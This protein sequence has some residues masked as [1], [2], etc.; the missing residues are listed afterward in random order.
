MPYLILSQPSVEYA[1][2]ISRALWAISRPKSARD[3][4][5]VSKLYTSWIVH[6]DGR[7]ALFLPNENKYIHPEGEIDSFVTLVGNSSVN[8]T[9][10]DS[11]GNETI[12]ALTYRELLERTRGG[13]LNFLTA[14]QNTPAFSANVR[15]RA[16]LEADGWF[17][18]E[19]V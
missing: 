10:I 4:K 9:T 12:E 17:L 15:N 1:E 2:A 5:D 13:R 11:E 7:V 3:S 18:G 8:V 14:A 16:E 6:S 19:E